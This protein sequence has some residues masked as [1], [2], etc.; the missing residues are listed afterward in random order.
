M[1]SAPTAHMNKTPSTV[2]VAGKNGIGGYTWEYATVPDNRSNWEKFKT[3]IWNPETHQFLGRTGKSWGGIFIFYVIFYGA[4]AVF[5]AICMKFLMMTIDDHYPKW[6]LDSSIIG[7]NPGMGYRPMAV[8]I[9]KGS[10]IWYSASN[11]SNVDTWVH[12]LNNFLDPYNNSRI[13][14]GAGQNQQ[15]CDFDRPPAPGKVCAVEINSKAWGPCTF[16]TNY[17]FPQASPCIFLK[18][19]RIY[20][21]QPELYNDVKSL[22]SDMP[23]DLK[24][25]INNTDKKHRNMVWVSCSGEA[26]NDR[27]NIGEIEI[28]PRPGFPSYYYPYQNIKGYLSPIVAVHFKRPKLHILINVECRAWAKN[29]FYKRSLQNR[30]GSVHFELLVD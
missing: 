20:G 7:T 10:L 3:T 29:I 14:P 1:L 28:Y 30:E 2:S 22:P 19:N 5:F 9:E 21:W 26:P 6:Q 27:E 24:K 23:E 11:S 25:H 8:E 15:I 18:L 13:L 12:S 16:H 17:S 4:L